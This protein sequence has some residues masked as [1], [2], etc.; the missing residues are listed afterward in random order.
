MSSSVQHRKHFFICEIAC[1]KSTLCNPNDLHGNN[2]G[3]GAAAAAPPLR[4]GARDVSRNGAW[5]WYKATTLLRAA[6]HAVSALDMAGCGVHPARLSDVR[7]FED[8]S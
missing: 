5:C 2:G 7:S 1:E 6:G 8:Y 3:Q 4:A